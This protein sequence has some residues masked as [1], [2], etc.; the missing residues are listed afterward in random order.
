MARKVI[1]TDDFTDEK[2]AETVAFSFEGK[3]YEID[4]AEE[5]R[6]AFA[7]LLA[8]YIQAGRAAQAPVSEQ[9]PPISA[10]A[11]RERVAA[12]RE[13]AKAQGMQVLDSGRLPFDVIEAYE[14][15]H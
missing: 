14:K 3:D 5:N 9:K 13:W 2:G 8:P 10:A 6:K 12:I 11:R 7:E 4:L 1:Y 15:A